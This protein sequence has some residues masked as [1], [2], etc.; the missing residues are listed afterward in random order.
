[1][2][3]CIKNNRGI[4]AYLIPV[5]VLLIFRF[6]LR[7]YLCDDAFI[8]FK[9]ALNLAENKGL[10]F[11][12]GERVFLV[13]TPFWAFMLTIPAVF[14]MDLI[15]SARLIGIL[16][17]LAFLLAA[18]H[19]G[20]TLTKSRATG[21]F[22]AILMCTH[23]VYLFSSFSG[24]ETSLFL[25]SI[26]LSF[27]YLAQ[28]RYDLSLIF[29]SF[30]LWIRFDSAALFILVF[31]WIYCKLNIKPIKSM[32]SRVGT[33]L[34]SLVIIGA[35]LIFGCVQYCEIIPNSVKAKHAVSPDFLS[36]DWIHGAYKLLRQ[37]GNSVVL[38][39]STYWYRETTPFWIMVIAAIIGLIRMVKTRNLKLTAI[40]AYTVLYS[41]IFILSGNIQAGYYPWY[42]AP[43]L[44][45]VYL[46]SAWGVVYIATRL[47]GIFKSFS[48]KQVVASALTALFALIWVIAITGPLIKDNMNLGEL[49]YNRERI[50][51][52]AAIWAGEYLP[53][54]S[55]IAAHE[56]GVI[57]YYSREDILILDLYGILRNKDDRALDMPGMVRK[58]NPE[59]IFAA[60]QTEC[61]S[62]IE[63]ALPSEYTWYKYRTLDIAIRNDL[64]YHLGKHFPRLAEIDSRIN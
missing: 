53:E 3:A 46:L 31:I 63:S 4:L 34:P 29:A 19:V 28:N 64:N 16:M 39:R 23:P 33:F 37:F 10:V 13:T 27:I 1:M 14:G 47:A 54:N 21:M 58:Y 25:F 48:D 22:F 18:V 2:T 49:E 61:R 60:E 32:A 55:I 7:A 62:I 12:P 41:L 57:G 44:L 40:L 43:P 8:T 9:S 59:L 52:A 42:F 5:F 26:L 20:F 30:S 45:G 51:K 11:N 17:E 56:I 36:Y 35:Y 38:G 6:L 50:Y 24:M 15:I